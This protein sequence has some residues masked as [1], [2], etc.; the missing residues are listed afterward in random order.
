MVAEALRLD[1]NV[2]VMRLWFNAAMT[3]AA[4]TYDDDAMAAALAFCD[5]ILRT[6]TIAHTMLKSGQSIDLTGLDQGIGLLCAKSLDLPPEMG[7]ALRP[8]LSAVLQALDAMSLAL[9]RQNAG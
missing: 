1:A 2:S 4:A 9:D 5:A 3:I 8:R 6:I 7:R